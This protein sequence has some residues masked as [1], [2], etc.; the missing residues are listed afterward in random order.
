M[1]PR[2][3]NTRKFRPCFESLEHKQLLST[4]LLTLGTQPLVSV[5]VPVSSQV[6][7]VGVEPCGTGTGSIIITSG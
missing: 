7:H 5:T 4:G 6:V 1:L 2:N 3:S